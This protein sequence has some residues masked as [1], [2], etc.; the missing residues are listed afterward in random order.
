MTRGEKMVFHS[1]C[2]TV[3][4]LSRNV[5]DRD[6]LSNMADINVMNARDILADA[7]QL[8]EDDE[9]ERQP[10]CYVC[11]NPGRVCLEFGCT[12]AKDL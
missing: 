8:S 2:R 9:E 5:E 4:E 6:G 10:H 3:L 11:D 12:P 1:M 7:G